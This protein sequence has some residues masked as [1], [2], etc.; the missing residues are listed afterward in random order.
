[1]FS[2]VFSVSFR[3]MKVCVGRCVFLGLLVVRFEVV[4]VIVFIISV[5]FLLMLVGVVLL[6]YKV[7]GSFGIDFVFFKVF[8][9]CFEG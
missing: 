5:C 1:M 4:V 9:V 8:L 3:G 7:G 2:V 6:L